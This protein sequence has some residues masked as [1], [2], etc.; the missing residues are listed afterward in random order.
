MIS[1]CFFVVI[2][3]GCQTKWETVNG[4]F[5]S[6]FFFSRDKKMK[7]WSVTYILLAAFWNIY[8]ICIGRKI[9][10]YLVLSN[11][12]HFHFMIIMCYSYNSI[13]FFKM[14]LMIMSKLCIDSIL[15]KLPT[16]LSDMFCFMFYWTFCHLGNFQWVFLWFCYILS[17][18]WNNDV[19]K[20]I[21]KFRNVHNMSRCKNIW[22]NLIWNMV[23]KVWKTLSYFTHNFDFYYTL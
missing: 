17:K 11:N 12:F 6:F 3:N 21:S 14:F 15:M 7:W 19:L 18:K 10:K 1:S 4:W 8:D 2:C 23:F 22:K 16:A 20:L 9:L 5:C 13:I